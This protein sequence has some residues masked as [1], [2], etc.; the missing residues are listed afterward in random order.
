MKKKNNSLGIFNKYLKSVTI[1]QWLLNL[2]NIPI[3]LLNANLMSYVVLSATNGRTREVVKSGI[4]LMLILIGYSL[5][6]SMYN[7]KLERT[8][9]GAETVKKSL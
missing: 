5:F 2:T 6:Q 4:E 8:K 3:G 7:I 9:S 1:A